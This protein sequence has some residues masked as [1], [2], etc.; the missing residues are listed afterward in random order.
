[1]WCEQKRKLSV[2]HTNTH[3]EILVPREDPIKKSIYHVIDVKE[4]I[5]LQL[6]HGR[7]VEVF[8]VD[9]RDIRDFMFGHEW[10][11]VGILQL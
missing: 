9:H 6:D 3:H 4:L 8:Y 7:E 11:D 10:L 1:M 2:A 5:P